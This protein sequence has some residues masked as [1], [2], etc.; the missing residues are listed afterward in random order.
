MAIG[1]LLHRNLSKLESN[2]SFLCACELR[3]H[4]GVALLRRGQPVTTARTAFLAVLCARTL[5]D[6]SING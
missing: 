2:P 4:L 1:R 3:R 5:P 6:H